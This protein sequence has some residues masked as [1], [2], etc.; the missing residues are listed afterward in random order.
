MAPE[1]TVHFGSSTSNRIERY[2]KEIHERM[3]KFLKCQ[4][5]ELLER[6]HYD[7][8]D[9]DDRNILAVIYIPIFRRE[10]NIFVELWNNSRSRFQKE[11]LDA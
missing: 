4:L 1:D 9:E 6:G 11:H 10:V 5:L 7:P 2:W 8:E 3:E